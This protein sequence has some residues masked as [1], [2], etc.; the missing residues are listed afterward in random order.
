MRPQPLVEIR[1]AR[2][3]EEER[4]QRNLPRRWLVAWVADRCV[5]VICGA[6]IRAGVTG[7]RRAALTEACA[8]ARG[9]A[10]RRAAGGR[11]RG[12]STL[13]AET[14][15]RAPG[16]RFGGLA[17]GSASAPRLLMRAAARLCVPR[18][19]LAGGVTSSPSPGTSRD[20]SKRIGLASGMGVTQHPA[21]THTLNRPEYLPVQTPAGRGRKRPPAPEHGRAPARDG[22]GR[23]HLA[24]AEW[25]SSATQALSA[26]TAAVRTP[27]AGGAA[28]SG[29]RRPTPS[30]QAF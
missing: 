16:V 2:I 6:C 13:A 8:A 3:E 19:G 26:P 7:V 15:G 10:I 27:A 1:E 21:G 28:Q 20:M 18:G 22:R 14:V 29:Q 9:Q 24:A 12:G 23:A 17:S 30:C 25:S 4:V 5:I 11:T